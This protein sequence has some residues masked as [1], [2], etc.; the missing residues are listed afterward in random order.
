MTN[1]QLHRQDVV[2]RT[3]RAARILLS[4]GTEITDALIADLCDQIGMHP[5]GFRNLF[6]TNEAL[7]DTINDDLIEECASRLRHGV[8]QFHPTALGDEGFIQAA[9]TLARA[10]PLDRSGLIIRASR[11]L[12][13]LR[14]VNSGQSALDGDRR[15]VGELTDVLTLLM[16]RLQRE[17]L[18]STALAV[19]VILDT[20]ER[21]FEA[22]VLAGHDENDFPDSPYVQRTLPRLLS[23]V[24]NPVLRAEKAR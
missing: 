8:E 12:R 10:W 2:R 19:R 16:E 4:T 1:T 3:A 5:R 15:Y 11:R 18:W 6:P 20:Y 23:E 24:S 22:W 21:S 14:D 13:A 17:F 7:L 9:T